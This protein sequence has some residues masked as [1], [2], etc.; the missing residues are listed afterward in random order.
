MEREIATSG[1]MQEGDARVCENNWF[2]R[3]SR[4]TGKT[5]VSRCVIK[6]VS[7][8]CGLESVRDSPDTRTHTHLDIDLLF[9]NCCTTYH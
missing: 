6:S 2:E 4:R 8:V 5:Q 3:C 7:G 9:P 1:D